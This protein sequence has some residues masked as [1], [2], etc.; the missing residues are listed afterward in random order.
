MV[1]FREKYHLW[2]R[3]ALPASKSNVAQLRD[4]IVD[5]ISNLSRIIKADL[6]AITREIDQ[7]SDDVSGRE[8][9]VYSKIEFC[10]KDIKKISLAFSHPKLSH[11]VPQP[12]LVSHSKW[13]SYLSSQFNRPGVRVLEVGSRNVTGIN[14]RRVFSQAE[15]VGFDFYDGENVDVVGDAH[16]LSSYFHDQKFDLILSSAVFEHLHMPWIVASEIQKLLKIGGY[17]FV[18][19]HFSHSTPER[20]WNF[21]QFQ[22]WV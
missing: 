3:R 9:N 5:Q 15:Y 7:I 6:Q 2:R 12:E 1:S 14:S 8:G 21:F 13:Q 16:I 10:T 20:P 22:T 11:A 19:T 17:V 18:E 4:S